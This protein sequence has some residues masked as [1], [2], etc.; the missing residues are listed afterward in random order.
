MVARRGRASAPPHPEDPVEMVWVSDQAA[1]LVPLWV[2]LNLPSSPKEPSPGHS[3]LFSDLDS[4]K[5]DNVF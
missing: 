1:L 4:N 2:G 5:Q 3:D